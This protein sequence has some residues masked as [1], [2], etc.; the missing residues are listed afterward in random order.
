MLVTETKKYFLVPAS[1]ATIGHRI[2]IHFSVVITE[3][4]FLENRKKRT[5]SPWKG[6]KF[7]GPPT[8]L[9]LIYLDGVV[10]LGMNCLPTENLGRIFY[11]SGWCLSQSTDPSP[12]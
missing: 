3:K 10:C 5:K 7:E 9:K 8:N 2:S 11:L 6:Q 12:L 1:D 4:Q